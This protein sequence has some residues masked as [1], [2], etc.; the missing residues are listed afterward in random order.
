M[1]TKDHII[2]GPVKFNNKEFITIYDVNVDTQVY[3][4]GFASYLIDEYRYPTAKEL[5][6]L[7]REH[8]FFESNNRL[9]YGHIFVK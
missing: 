4:F 9:E 2:F 3:K 5:D 6:E 8:P 7:C 1:E